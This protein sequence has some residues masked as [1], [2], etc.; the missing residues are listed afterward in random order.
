M[1]RVY[2]GYCIL[3]ICDAILVFQDIISQGI[4]SSLIRILQ[5]YLGRLIGLLV[6]LYFASLWEIRIKHACFIRTRHYRGLSVL[7]LLV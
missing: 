3:N 7:S 5:L 4:K 6:I 2:M 1:E